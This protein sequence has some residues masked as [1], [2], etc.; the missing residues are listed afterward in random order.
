MSMTAPPDIPLASDGDWL[1][2]LAGRRRSD[3]SAAMSTV[4]EIKRAV[5]KLPPRKK[6][7]LARW[8]Q[9]HVDDRLNDDELMAI[10]AE[11]ARAL[12][13]READYAKRKAR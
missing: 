13:R 11:G 2:G 12:D 7:A 4:A 8:L 3:Y 5:S 1:G 10:A 9:D 6:L